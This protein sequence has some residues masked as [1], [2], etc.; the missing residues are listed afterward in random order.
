[1]IGQSKSVLVTSAESTQA[2]YCQVSPNPKLDTLMSLLR[3]AVLSLVPG[4]FK[5][6]DICCAQFTEDQEWYRA[7]VVAVTG[8]AAD[9][10]YLDYGNSETVPLSGLRALPAKLMK[11]APQAKLC[12]LARGEDDDEWPETAEVQQ[13]FLDHV[14]SGE[15]EVTMLELDQAGLDGVTPVQV[16]VNGSDIAAE[17][18]N[19]LSNAAPPQVNGHSHPPAAAVTTAS[20]PAIKLTTGS[21]L[22]V[23]IAHVESMTRFSCQL[24]GTR[25]RFEEL[26]VN[27]YRLYNKP[28]DICVLNASQITAGTL[29]CVHS[30]M[31]SWCRARVE[32][33]RGESVDVVLVDYGSPETVQKSGCWELCAAVCDIEAQCFVASLSCGDNGCSDDLKTPVF[34]SLVTDG[35]KLQA[36][37][38]SLPASTDHNQ[39]IVVNLQ[40][41]KKAYISDLLKRT[42][43]ANDSRQVVSIGVEQIPL[44]TVV[45]KQTYEVVVVLDDPSEP[46]LFQC[47]LV[48]N[49]VPFEEVQRKLTE[50]PAPAL[51]RIEPG[52]LCIGCSSQDKVPYRAMI[53]SESDGTCQIVFLDFGDRE[54]IPAEFLRELPPDLCKYPRQAI[55]AMIHSSSAVQPADLRGCDDHVVFSAVFAK[56]ADGRYDVRLSSSPHQP[57]IDSSKA[58]AS[59]APESG[60]HPASTVA[61]TNTAA[62]PATA[63]A[64][65]APAPVQWM[66][67][68]CKLGKAAAFTAGAVCAVAHADSP[69]AMWLQL[70]TGQEQL[71]TLQASLYDYY[72]NADNAKAT[73]ITAKDMVNGLICC[74]QFAEDG[75]W[76]RAVVLESSNAAGAAGEVRVR[77]ID[78]GNVATVSTS[79][80]HYLMLSFREQSIFA[81]VCSYSQLSPA[82]Q[83]RWTDESRVMFSNAIIGQGEVVLKTVEER[84]GL[85]TQVSFTDD[86]CVQ[87]LVSANLARF[88][89]APAVKHLNGTSPVAA[90]KPVPSSASRTNSPAARANAT[91][92]SPTARKGVAYLTWPKGSVQLVTMCAVESP[93]SFWV[94]ND[95][96]LQGLHNLVDILIQDVKAGNGPAKQIQVGA[97]YVLRQSAKKYARCSCEEVNAG[98]VK[99]HLYDYGHCESVPESSLYPWSSFYG[100]LLPRIAVHCSLSAAIRPDG[101]FPA[102]TTD[103]LKALMKRDHVQVKV[104]GGSTQDLLEVRVFQHGIDLSTELL[105]G[106]AAD[107]PIPT[108]PVPAARP[109]FPVVGGRPAAARENRTP[110]VSAKRPPSTSAQRQQASPPSLSSLSLSEKTTPTRP[111]SNSPVVAASPAFNAAQCQLKSRQA[112]DAG[113]SPEP[114]VVNRGASPVLPVSPQRP[115]VP[116]LTA[117]SPLPKPKQM[118]TSGQPSFPRLSTQAGNCHKVRYVCHDEDTGTTRY[119]CQLAENDQQL[120]KIAASITTLPEDSFMSIE[121]AVVGTVCCAPS[122]DGEWYRACV[123]SISAGQSAT[124]RFVDYGNAEVVE[125]LGELNAD[126]LSFPVQAV[127]CKLATPSPALIDAGDAGMSVQFVEECG[128]MWT[129]NLDQ[130]SAAAADT[131]AT[132]PVTAVSTTG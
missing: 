105:T 20:I 99:V 66:T 77:Y 123:E 108:T 49:A 72:N 41:E 94:Q 73:A 62:A 119:W 65:T 45:D 34:K 116:A 16:W 84:P 111:R 26:E 128:G 129:V 68:G 78:Y 82:P 43:S 110:S 24:M 59:A 75:A 38:L 14:L 40:D 61:V 113:K 109:V 80:V 29:C 87:Q 67:A 90:A 100:T 112:S 91:A 36:T 46:N 50:V 63:A 37:I 6:G 11:L 32:K 102:E 44:A 31:Y 64:A 131:A 2:F 22:Q 101:G 18:G 85:G 58:T 81:T 79:V 88:P 13:A 126:L 97:H 92:S 122:S 33:V 9:V 118:A 96:S 74:A 76:Y 104:V 35:K 28:V 4:T 51:S 30:D 69:D 125:S 86:Y 83:N 47:Q 3:E 89:T 93:T 127:A 25:S 57:A 98:S 21:I 52:Q 132:A 115:A 130:N 19:V 106:K 8:D 114:A 54:S 12:S 7:R 48:E 103:R 10:L 56:R 95:A 117:V 71:E 107:V 15:G 60:T 27:L 124:V 1:M 70:M 53:E 5:A 120:E 121:S 23:S 55:P 42:C 17:L 39:S